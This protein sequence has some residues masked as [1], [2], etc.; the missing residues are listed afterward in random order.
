MPPKK[1][2][3][4]AAEAPAEMVDDGPKAVVVDGIAVP[5][6]WVK[7]LH[8]HIE[9][10]PAKGKLRDRSANIRFDKK[11]QDIQATGSE[12]P[13]TNTPVAGR[14]ELERL[15]T[16]EAQERHLRR[17]NSEALRRSPEKAVGLQFL[18]VKRPISEEM[19][20][21]FKRP[22]TE[23]QAPLDVL[24]RGRRHYSQRLMEDIDLAQSAQLSRSSPQL[25][26]SH[27]DRVHG[28]YDN[29]RIK[30][31]PVKPEQAKPAYMTFTKDDRTLSGS[32]RPEPN[33]RRYA[34]LPWDAKPLQ[35]PAWLVRGM[36]KSS[37][38]A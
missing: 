16:H 13:S 34:P 22:E 9:L 32:L 7:Q 12:Q 31:A 26:C 17:L 15:R 33:E 20:S 6:T 18:E 10:D 24:N 23:S 36:S 28:W 35:K 30:D 38:Y 4:A 8:A 29:T 27:L 37:S 3:D 5:N 21:L 19:L 1:A 25:R 11:M 2:P 14:R